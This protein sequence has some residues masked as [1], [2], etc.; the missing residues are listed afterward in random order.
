MFTLSRL[1]GLAI[2]RRQVQSPAPGE[3]APQGEMISRPLPPPPSRP[4]GGYDSGKHSLGESKVMNVAITATQNLTGDIMPAYFRTPGGH[5]VTVH[6][7]RLYIPELNLLM[8]PECPKTYGES[9]DCP[10]LPPKF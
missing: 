9:S 1:S 7:C 3:G 6:I 2:R 4:Q 8:N 10:W 5:S